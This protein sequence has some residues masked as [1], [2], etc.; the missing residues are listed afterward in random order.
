LGDVYTY[1]SIGRPR[2]P[3]D[4]FDGSASRILGVGYSHKPAAAFMANRN[5]V[6]VR[7]IVQGINDS[8][9]A[10]TGHTKHP[11]DTLID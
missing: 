9:I 5:N 6:N 4:E 11:V 7:R 10:F 1:G 2:P 3:A 8:E